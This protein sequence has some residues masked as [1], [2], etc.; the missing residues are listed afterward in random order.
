[1]S[2]KSDEE[3]K[4]LE[5]LFSEDFHMEFVLDKCAKATSEYD[6]ILHK[7]LANEKILSKNTANL[8]H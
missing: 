8:K 6:G 7:N 3:L 2:S 1:M 5:K 4:Q